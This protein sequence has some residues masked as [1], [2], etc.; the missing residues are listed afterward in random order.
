MFPLDE[1][2]PRIWEVL[3]TQQLAERTLNDFWVVKEV[4][5]SH[6]VLNQ[7]V[8]CGAGELEAHSIASTKQRMVHVL[9]LLTSCVVWVL[10][11]A[12]VD[13]PITLELKPRS[14]NLP[15]F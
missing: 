14:M 3:L 7:T 1:S 12:D 9:T 6:R 5:E 10:I 11:M 8:G 13:S 2:I 15:F 4:S